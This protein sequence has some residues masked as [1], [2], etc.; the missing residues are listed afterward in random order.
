MWNHR[1]NIVSAAYREKWGQI[2]WS[3]FK[4]MLFFFFII[5]ILFCFIWI[6]LSPCVVYEYLSLCLYKIKR[7][8]MTTV[9]QNTR[10][11]VM[12]RRLFTIYDKICRSVQRN[13][14]FSQETNECWRINDK[15]QGSTFWEE[16]CMNVN[17]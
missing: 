5:N 13:T 3:H 1:K 9:K 14:S 17:F 2:I 7:T 15:L 11:D 4:E 10:N 8:P 12:W 16:I 6:L